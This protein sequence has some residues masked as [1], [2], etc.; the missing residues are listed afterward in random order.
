[1]TRACGHDLLLIHGYPRPVHGQH[2][3]DV[4]ASIQGTAGC[5]Q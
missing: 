5:H 1:L 2:A 4:Q 3:E